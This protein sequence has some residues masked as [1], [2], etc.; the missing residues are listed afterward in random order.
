MVGEVALAVVLLISA[1]LL[2]RS[3]WRL[4]AVEP[5]FQADHVLTWKVALTK[6]KYPDERRQGAL[7]EQLR[8]R[9]AALPGV[10]SVGGVSDLPLGGADIGA[11]LYLEG[12][13]PGTRR[14]T[15]HQVI[16]PGYLRTLGIPLLQGRDVTALDTAD[17]E[18]VVLVNE[19]AAQRFWPGKDPVGQR[20]QLGG[21]G[22]VW[23]TV[24]GI[25]G[26]VRHEG[27]VEKARPEVYQ[28]VLQKTFFFMSFVART[29]GEPTALVP[30]VR[31]AVGALDSELPIADVRPMKQLLTT[32]TARPRFVSLLVALFAG[33]SLV[34]AGVGLYGVIAYMARQRT[35]EIGIRMALGARPTDVLRLVVGRGMLLSLVG[36]GLG[37]LGAWATTRTM[38]SLL[39]EVSA[40]DPWTFGMLALLVMAVTLLATWLPARR[41]TF[42][43]P[44]VA[45][46]GE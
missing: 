32:A 46:R 43:D 10:R 27:L 4:Q 35:Q 41:A 31:S 23:R 20:V 12:D 44:L 34:L 18:P 19:T 14:Y 36:V 40:T 9:V 29:Q 17:A 45:L 22:Q 30:A 26:D 25:V 37:L 3:L 1:G 5:G 15:G 33:L 28:P 6:D 8:E 16:T 38:G 11:A 24:V 7:F 42:V 39:F 2:L 21:Q 13:E